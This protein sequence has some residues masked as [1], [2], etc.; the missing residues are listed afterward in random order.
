MLLLSTLFLLCMSTSVIHA[1]DFIVTSK[2]GFYEP[3][4]DAEGNQIGERFQNPAIN[5]AGERIGTSQGFAFNF[6]PNST[7][8]PANRNWIFFLDDGQ[9]EV[10]DQ[11]I[12]SATGSYEKYSGGRVSQNIASVDPDYVSEITLIQ[13]ETTSPT[14]DQ[15][16]DVPATLRITSEGGFYLPFMSQDGKKQY[17]EMFQNPILVKNTTS[18]DWIDQSMIG[19]INQG[20]AFNYNTSSDPFIA[21]HRTLLMNRLFF[22]SGG[23]LTVLDNAIVEGTGIFSRYTGGSFNESVI[24]NDP[25][26]VAEII[27][28]EKEPVDSN[29]EYP[30]VVTFF[31]DTNSTEAIKEP[32]LNNMGAPIGERVHIP[33]NDEDGTRVG[34]VLGYAYLFPNPAG[35]TVNGNRR[36]FLKDGD[37][38]I[39]NNYIVHATGIYAGYVGG[40]APTSA[41]NKITIIPAAAAQTET[42]RHSAGYLVENPGR[43]SVVALVVRLMVGLLIQF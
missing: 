25:H 13:P 35:P 28:L 24:S 33:V 14:V 42:E 27:L 7:S 4:T 11:T 40:T 34:S 26:Y 36:L 8:D 12:V 6:A 37:L 18:G 32:I 10:M 17:G 1:Y 29:I 38:I 20:F 19:S 15:T 3:I 30:P 23:E 9:V 16:Q 21:A 39:F 2:G 22:L 31:L 5:D 41:G 43:A